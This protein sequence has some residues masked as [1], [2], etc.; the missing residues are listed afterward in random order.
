MYDR[1][2]HT[3]MKL[4]LHGDYVMARMFKYIIYSHVSLKRDT[5]NMISNASVKT[6]DALYNST[7]A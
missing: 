6:G 4:Y 7:K 5:G 1:F 3:I 2:N